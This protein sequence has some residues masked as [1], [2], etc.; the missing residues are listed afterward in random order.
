MKKMDK[1]QNK[2]K[3]NHEKNYEDQSFISKEFK[4][5]LQQYFKIHIDQFGKDLIT[6]KHQYFKIVKQIY[7]ALEDNE[8]NGL[9]KN[10]EDLETQISENQEEFESPKHKYV[11]DEKIEQFEPNS[12]TI[13]QK[14]L[15]FRYISV[16]KL[17]YKII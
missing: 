17:W 11:Q 16:Q 1:R 2:P 4:D 9:N 12:Q 8:S 15:G 14:N 7:E 3:L 5:Y 13:V 6:L 10:S